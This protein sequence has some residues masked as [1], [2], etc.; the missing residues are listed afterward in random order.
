MAK[1]YEFLLDFLHHLHNVIESLKQILVDISKRH[2]VTGK[3][4]PYNP[5]AKKAHFSSFPGDKLE[6]NGKKSWELAKDKN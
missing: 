3:I 5:L 1:I 2:N 4:V 6:S